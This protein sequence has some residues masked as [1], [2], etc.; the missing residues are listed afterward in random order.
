MSMLNI[1]VQ[2]VTS[3]A[4]LRTLESKEFKKMVKYAVDDAIFKARLNLEDAVAETIR[5]ATADGKVL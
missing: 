5:A 4:L 2:A 3:D 1:D